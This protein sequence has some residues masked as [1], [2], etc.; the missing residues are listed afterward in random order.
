MYLSINFFLQILDILFHGGT[1]VKEGTIGLK[2]A[3]EHVI[4]KMA[5]PLIF[6]TVLRCGDTKMKQIL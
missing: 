6:S 4:G 1:L 5:I 3:R 2:N